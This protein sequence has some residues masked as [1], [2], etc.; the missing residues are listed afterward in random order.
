MKKFSE[1]F[2][3]RDSNYEESKET[4]VLNKISDLIKSYVEMESI[5]YTSCD[6]CGKSDEDFDDNSVNIASSK[7]IELLKSEGLD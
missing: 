6:K 3:G 5:K 2:I 7:I 4:K 1:G